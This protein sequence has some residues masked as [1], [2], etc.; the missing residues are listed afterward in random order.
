MAPVKRATNGS[1]G[2]RDELGRRP[3]LEQP[4]LDE[5]TDPVGE[6]GGILEV[7][8]DENRRQVQHSQQ[9]T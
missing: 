6:R 2:R 7:V 3:D 4:P 5:H 8:R 9:V 1:A